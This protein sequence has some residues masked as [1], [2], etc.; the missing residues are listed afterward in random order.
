MKGVN[1]MAERKVPIGPTYDEMLHPEKIDPEIRSK[2]LKALKENELDPVN[3]F[4]INWKDKDGKV[5]KV[6]LPK[7]FTGVDANIV[8]LLGN[9]FPSGSHKVGPAYSVLIEGYVD[10]EID[11]DKHTIL[12]PSTG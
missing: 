11:P 7:E 2:A 12:G 10:G 1:N 3:L 8:V 4:N 5:R 6:V 9:D